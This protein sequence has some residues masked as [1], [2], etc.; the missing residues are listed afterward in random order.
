MHL[1]AE[2]SVKIEAESKLPKVME[3]LEKEGERKFMKNSLDK[4]G[5]EMLRERKAYVLCHVKRN[6]HDEEVIENIV[7]DGYC[8]R[9][10]EEDIKWEEE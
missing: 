2:Q 1:C 6:D 8:M 3:L 4:N 7:I 5:T 9:T 10:P